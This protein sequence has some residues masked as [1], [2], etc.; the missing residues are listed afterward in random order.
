MNKD[1]ISDEDAAMVFNQGAGEIERLRQRLAILEAKAE[2][3]D[4]FRMAL[5]GKRPEPQGYG[6]SHKARRAIILEETAL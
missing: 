1:R 3:I 4:V 2:V 5:S 6:R